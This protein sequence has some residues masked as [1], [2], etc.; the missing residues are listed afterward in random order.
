M[1]FAAV[2]ALNCLAAL[3][4]TLVGG[5]AFH[6]GKIVAKALTFKVLDDTQGTS[7]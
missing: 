2:E 3:L 1:Q 5:R 6:N 7:N 4:P